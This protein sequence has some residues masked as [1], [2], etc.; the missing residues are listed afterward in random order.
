MARVVVHIGM[1]KTG[2][3]SI[4]AALYRDRDRLLAHGIDYLDLGQN[5][6]RVVKVAVKGNA[7]RLKGEVVKTLGLA[8]GIGGYDVGRVVE[9]MTAKFAARRAETMIVSGE[10]FFN[11]DD[12]ECARF[13]ELLAPHFDEIRIIAYLR[14]PV[15]WASSRAQENIK[16]GHSIA[17][18]TGSVVD[19]PAR[20]PIVPR[21]RE[22]LER[23]FRVFGRQAVT[24]RPF[25]RAR[26]VGGDLIAD[27]LAAAGAR[28]EV[29]ALVGRPWNNPRTSH[30]AL[31]LIESHYRM[32]GRRRAAGG[33]AAPG[34]EKAAKKALKAAKKA[35]AADDD[36]GFL[37]KTDDPAYRSLNYWFRT[38]IRA[39]PGT[40]FRLPSPVLERVWAAVQDDLVWLR[41]ETGIPDLFADA[42]PAAGS[43][44]PV[45]G[46]E[47][48]DAL[49]ERLDRAVGRRRRSEFLLW[50]RHGPQGRVVSS[51]ARL[52][53][54]VGI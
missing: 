20:S 1:T 27:F 47:T 23:W 21:Y 2:S 16:H 9:A 24:L 11:M 37:G 44:G 41:D 53:R 35:A 51:V 25:D 13:R 22:R 4:Q 46:P 12:E 31:L 39:V 45:W 10:G 49:T 50:L 34:D 15:S 48:L 38:D 29:A 40:P 3:T 43:E 36:M 26:F 42:W 6:S 28:P 30:E 52:R 17:E 54:F 32:L 18:L 14:D 7:K 19:D 5:H 8:K 33:S